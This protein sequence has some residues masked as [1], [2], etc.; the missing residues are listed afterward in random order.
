MRAR[1]GEYSCK[2]RTS[3]IQRM[4]S[5]GAIKQQCFAQPKHTYLG[6]VDR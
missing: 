6:G 3:H 2:I 4:Q 5:K 1:R